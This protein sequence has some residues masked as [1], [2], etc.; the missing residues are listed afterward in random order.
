MGTWS[1]GYYYSLGF[2]GAM[3]VTLLSL[4]MSRVSKNGSSFILVSICCYG[5][6]IVKERQ[7]HG[8][9]QHQLDT[10]LL[11]RILLQILDQPPEFGPCSNFFQIGQEIKNFEI[12]KD[13][14]WCTNVISKKGVTFYLLSNFQ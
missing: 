13:M 10:C 8:S 5:N 4:R 11:S 9:G 7:N 12:S 2:S 14:T 3:S 1:K 6:P